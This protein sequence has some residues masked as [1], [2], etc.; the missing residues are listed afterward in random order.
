LNGREIATSHHRRVCFAIATTIRLCSHH[1]PELL[2]PHYLGKPSYEPSKQQQC[3][4]N[5]KN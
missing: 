1:P 4:K 2:V 3:Q 5:G